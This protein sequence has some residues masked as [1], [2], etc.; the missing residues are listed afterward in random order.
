MRYAALL[1]LLVFALCVE[2]ACAHDECW[3][4][5]VLKCATGSMTR[6]N[7]DESITYHPDDCDTISCQYSGD[8]CLLIPLPE[9]PMWMG[10]VA[11]VMT[12]GVVK[13][14]RG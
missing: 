8:G 10:L 13:R 14:L 11:A 3:D 9:P 12:L 4:T 1:A 2:P 7:P 6:L 5:E